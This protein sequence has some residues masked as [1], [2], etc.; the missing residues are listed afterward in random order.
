MQGKRLFFLWAIFLFMNRAFGQVEEAIP[1]NAVNYKTILDD[2]KD[3]DYLWLLVQPFTVDAGAMNLMIG[4]GMDLI[5]RP[6]SEFELS[7]GFRGN[8]FNVFD[9]HRDAARQGTTIQTQLSKREQGAL[10][11]T[12]PFT[13][14]YHLEIGGTYF[15]WDRLAD[16]TAKIHLSDGVQPEKVSHSE[17]ILVDAK[18]WQR[19]GVRLGLIS[20]AMTLSLSRAI[21]RQNLE[22]KGSEGTVLSQAGTKSANG[23]STPTNTNKIYSNFYS[24]GFFLGGVFST[25]KNI[26]LKTDRFG[27]VAHNSILTFYGDLMFNPFLR[28]ADVQTREVGGSQVETFSGKDIKTNNLGARIGLDLRFNQ[29]MYYALGIETGIRPSIQGQGFY[30]LLKVSFPAFSLT[31]KPQ[32]ASNNV[33]KNQ[34]LSQ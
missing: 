31:G 26:S 19:V 18:R 1:S 6:K 27:I 4:S 21:D 20:E 23:F 17:P 22:W 29:K 15:L 9:L 11:I 2:P 5:Y 33:G 24:T 13:R 10:V 3:M 28:I 32:R 8:V 14:N 30:G 34:S 16:G 12:Q 7:L 25:S